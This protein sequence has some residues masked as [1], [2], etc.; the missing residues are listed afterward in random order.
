MSKTEYIYLKK[1]NWYLYL[2][3][4]RRYITPT[5]YISFPSVKG[6]YSL[7]ICMKLVPFERHLEYLRVMFS[8]Q[9]II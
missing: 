7:N 3:S 6:N 5:I 4:I 2:H 8:T 9:G 1:K